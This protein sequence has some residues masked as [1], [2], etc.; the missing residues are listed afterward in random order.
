MRTLFPEHRLGRWLGAMSLAL[1]LQLGAV[2][3][4]QA[5]DTYTQTRH[6]IVLVNGLFGFS[7]I[8]PIRYFYGVPGALQAGGATVYTPPVSAANTTE[9]RGEQLIQHLRALQAAYGHT[10]F[11][12][13]G[14]SHGGPTARYVAAVAP[15]LVASVTSVS[16]PHA[17]SQA[18]DGLLAISGLTLTTPIVV[19]LGSAAS[20]AIQFI[21]G[22]PYL[23]TDFLGALLSMNSRGAAQFTQRFPQGAPTTACGQGPELVN[24]IRYYSAGGTHVLTTVIDPTDLLMQIS[25]TFFG[26]SA[27][28]GFVGRCSSHWGT[29]L[30]DNYHWNHFDSINQA[31]GLRGLFSQDPLAFYRAQAN[32]LKLAGL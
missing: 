11:N 3:A 10:R 16:S 18:A 13:I 23:T 19:A 29:V 22:T 32:R 7:Q 26:F 25:A 21:S 4:A 5:A 17:G 30:K 20:V 9:V 31:L 1:G 15:D 28:D 8:G 24:G 12:L 6:P 2:P 14:H 27:N